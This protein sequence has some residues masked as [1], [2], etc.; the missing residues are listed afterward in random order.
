LEHTKK[1]LYGRGIFEKIFQI[2]KGYTKSMFNITDNFQP[3][4][5]E[6]LTEVTGGGA[7]SGLCVVGPLA[8][9]LVPGV[10]GITTATTSGVNGITTATTSG[11]NGITTAT[12]SGVNGITTAS[13]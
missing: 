11:V 9:G 13:L 5:D 7:V 12:T 2:K 6:Q 1:C 8:D 3:L 4:T 10:N